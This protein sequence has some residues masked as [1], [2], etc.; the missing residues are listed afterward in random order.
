MYSRDFDLALGKKSKDLH[1]WQLL[2]FQN[3]NR[4]VQGETGQ[5]C[6]MGPPVLQLC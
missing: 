1:K 4:R 3:M 2:V 5:L 6:G